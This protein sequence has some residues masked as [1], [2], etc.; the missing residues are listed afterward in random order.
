MTGMML[1]PILT[2]KLK[3]VFIANGIC[4][5]DIPVDGKTWYVIQGPV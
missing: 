5:F 2:L 1:S 3:Q 4:K